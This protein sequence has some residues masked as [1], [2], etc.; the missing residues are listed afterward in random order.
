LIQQEAER[1]TYY[2]GSTPAPDDSWDDS[3][4]MELVA[5]EGWIKLLYIDEPPSEDM[6][7]VNDLVDNIKIHGVRTS[8]GK[9]WNDGLDKMSKFTVPGFVGSK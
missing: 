2:I 6:H 7:S 3:D 1:S 5:K 8:V 9:L 4:Q